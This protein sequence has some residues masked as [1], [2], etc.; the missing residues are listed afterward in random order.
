MQYFL[1][2]THPCHNKVIVI[3]FH[4]KRFV[5]KCRNASTTKP[6]NSKGIS[7][8]IVSDT[9]VN[10][11]VDGGNVVGTNTLPKINY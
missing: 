1:S 8:S 3:P 6:S 5:F 10:V 2:Q 4:D 11:S 9:E 7:G